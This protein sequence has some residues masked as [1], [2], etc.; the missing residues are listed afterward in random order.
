[1][2]KSITVGLLVFV[3][4]TFGQIYKIDE[5]KKLPGSINTA[6][7]ESL[8]IF[9][10]DSSKLYFM[11]TF[12]ARNKGGIN[13]QDIWVSFRDEAGGY[14]EGKQVTELNSKFNNAVVGI[15]KD[16]KTV[17]LLNTYEGKKDTEKGLSF[18]R[19]EEKSGWSKPQKVQIPNLVIKGDYYGFHVSSDEN[20]V[21]ISYEGPGTFG[22]EDLFVSRKVDGSWTSPLNLGSV[23]NSS[24]YE[25]SPFLSPNNDTLFFSSNGHGG[26]GDA[27][28]FYAV[29]LDDSW[30]SWSK[31][32]NLGE[33]VNSSAFDACFSYHGDRMYWSTGRDGGYSNIYTAR[34]IQP[35]PLVVRATQQN[36][37]VNKGSDG[38][39]DL[40][41]S[42]GVG[43]YTYSWSNGMSSEDL[44]NIPAGEYK[45]IVTDSR[46]QQAELVV[47]ITEPDPEPIIIAETPKPKVG[48]DLGKLLELG[49]IYFDLNSSYLRADSKP[50]LDK[51]VK[52]MNANSKLVIEIG[53]H[54]DCRG[55]A[56][57]NQWL[58]DR[59]ANSTIEYIQKR[60]SN[61][62]RVSGKGYGESKLVNQC[63]CEGEQQSDCS[64]DEHQ[65]NRR[66]E[67]IIVNM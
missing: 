42:G 35:E 37:S 34:F 45:V 15:S 50:E 59:R 40:T 6:A 32:V 26:F 28:I 64:E 53:S 58:S 14:S 62:S 54:T 2:R 4:T 30:T 5:V 56:K 31:P 22:K 46:G 61:P 20:F 33:K 47:V 8:P 57:Y 17:Y 44:T 10:P 29:R 18:S 48:D 1:M 49:N 41:V 60:I 38:K 3:Q 16:G 12:D 9:T 11:R 51:I 21:L 19:F 55:T 36:V 7:E 25:M 23:I 66:T 39:I 13:D 43:P 24:G 65:I 27:D 63:A 67:F 52:A